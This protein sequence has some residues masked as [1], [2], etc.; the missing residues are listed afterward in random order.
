MRKLALLITL[1]SAPLAAQSKPSWCVNDGWAPKSDKGLHFLAGSMVGI[2]PY[3]VAKKL[4]YKH[5]WIH[6]LAWAIAAGIW[7]EQYDKKHGGRPDYADATYTALGGFTIGMAIHLGEKKK[8]E[9]ATAPK[10]PE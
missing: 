1:L 4:G 3:F 9:F 2:A 5:P 7:K 10:L 6:S 8:Q